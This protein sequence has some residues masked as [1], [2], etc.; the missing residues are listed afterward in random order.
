[1]ATVVYTCSHVNMYVRS[2]LFSFVFSR[3]FVESLCSDESEHDS[4]ESE[5]DSDD[6]GADDSYHDRKYSDRGI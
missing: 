5:H 4:D 3:N 6:V 2:Y 1:M